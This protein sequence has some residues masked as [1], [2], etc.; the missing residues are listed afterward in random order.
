[1]TNPAIP[2]PTP[3]TPGA[4]PD[5]TSGIDVIP[6]PLTGVP[7]AEA[8]EAAEAAAGGA[9][10]LNYENSQNN[11][12]NAMYNSPNGDPSSMLQTVPAMDQAGRNLNNGVNGNGGQ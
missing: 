7:G 5:P 4:G 1:M 8:A 2:A 11:V 12:Y 3:L 6:P 10:L 9:G